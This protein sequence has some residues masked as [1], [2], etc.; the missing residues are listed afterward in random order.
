MDSVG[1]G[2]LVDRCSGRSPLLGPDDP[3]ACRIVNPGG[4]LPAVF[5]CDHASNRVPAALANLGLSAEELERHIAWDIGSAEMT[6]R[7]SQHFDA[8][9]VL[10]S[11]SRLV[12]DCNRRLEDPQSILAESDGTVV[13]GNCNLAPEEAAR[14][15]D[16]CFWPYHEAVAATIEGVEARGAV[17]PVIMMH[18]FT[19]AMGA[20]KRPWHIGVLWERDGRIALPLMDRLRARG[21]LCVG[22]NQP[23]TASSPHSY[24]MPIHAARCGRA[25]VQIEI[26]Q[27]LI[28]DEEGIARWTAVMIDALA[29]LFHDERLYRRMDGP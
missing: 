26:R 14:R 9:A 5:L 28:G 21:D 10:A 17:A 11:Y 12:I 23:Y 15:V 20:V 19:P 16:A 13:P 29:E 22:D 6:R 8:P 24:T 18:S 25:N 4:A 2:F 7:L 3:P 1:D 27:D